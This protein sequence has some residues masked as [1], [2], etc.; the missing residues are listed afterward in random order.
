VHCSAQ[1]ALNGYVVIDRGS[2]RHGLSALV[3]A[4]GSGVL[5]LGDVITHGIGRRRATKK[6][7]KGCKTVPEVAN[8][9][10]F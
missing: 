1:L 8:D 5:I 6:G 3:E 2:F 7:W 4:C 9:N 10:Q